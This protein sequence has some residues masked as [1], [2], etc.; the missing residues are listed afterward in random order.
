MEFETSASLIPLNPSPEAPRFWQL[1]KS[2][3]RDFYFI[4]LLEFCVEIPFTLVISGSTIYNINVQKF[5]EIEAGAIFAFIGLAVGLFAILFSNFPARYGVKISIFVGNILG[6]LTNILLYQFRNRYAQVGIM[7]ILYIPSISL[8][9]ISLKLAVKQYT[10]PETRSFGFSLF[11]MVFFI[12]AGISGAATD[13]LLTNFGIR[14]KPF[15]YVFLSSICLYA[16]ALGLTF[17]IRDI[18]IELTGE[19]IRNPV[20]S[21][22]NG[23]DY[24]KEVIT[25]KRFW[26][27][28]SLILLLSVVKSM[29]FHLNATLPEYMYRDIG[30][31]AHFGYM[32]AG[33]QI[34]LIIATPLLT[35]LVNY[36]TSFT[37]LLIGSFITALSVNVFLLGSNYYT[38]ALFVATIS[39]GEA[40]YA[41]RLIDYTLEVAPKGKEAIYIGMANIP[42]FFSLIITGISSGILLHLVCPD[43][44]ENPNRTCKIMWFWI[45]G[46]S[47]IACLVMIILKKYFVQ[48]TNPT[49]NKDLKN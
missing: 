37:L 45:G 7:F 47:L 29:Y 12:A 25:T 24:T 1:V 46:Y 14:M 26:K 43:I 18:D 4:Y 39:F 32:M 20:E 30:E 33:H 48:I 27:F 34:V 9:F 38:I 44:Q 36:F 19:N 40:I 10:F 35:C 8:N 6:L 41:P 23:W 21:S 17:I 15:D 49:I 31:G 28:F 5:T 13:L 42:N 2:H 16:I 22:Q 11:Y 3:P